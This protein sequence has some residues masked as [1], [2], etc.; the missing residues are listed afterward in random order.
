MKNIEFP[1][2]KKSVDD[3]LY[4]EEGNIPVNKI[5]TIGSM[6]MILGMILADES[7]AAHRSHSSHSSHRSHSS[8]YGGHSSHSS[9]SSGYGGHNSHSNHSSHSNIAPSAA[10]MENMYT[11]PKGDVVNIDEISK[12][13]QPTAT[14]PATT[15]IKS[16]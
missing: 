7:Y 10:T 3:F 15:D 13:V 16:K 6:I 8:G 2:L 12:V 14:L 5:L 4:D 9:H 11:V 1:H